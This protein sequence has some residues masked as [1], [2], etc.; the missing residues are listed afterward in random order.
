[1]RI[2][3][4]AALAALCLAGACHGPEG[5]GFMT[6]NLISGPGVPLPPVV[7]LRQ[8]NDDRARHVAAAKEA[9]DD[10]RRL[11]EAADLRR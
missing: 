4:A 3:L 8:P 2:G 7:R 6:F 10:F 9:R 1:M 5:G 11:V